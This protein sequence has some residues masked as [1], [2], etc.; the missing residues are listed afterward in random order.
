MYRGLFNDYRRFMQTLTILVL[1]SSF[2]LVNLAHGVQKTSPNVTNF[3]VS[4]A[5]LLTTTKKN[6]K[7][8]IDSAYNKI[9]LAY[10]PLF[11]NTNDYYLMRGPDFQA[12]IQADEFRV[13]LKQP[14]R[15]LNT[16]TSHALRFQFLGADSKARMNGMDKLPGKSNYFIGDNPKQWR[17]GVP[18]YE[19][20]KVEKIYPGIDLVYY[21]V[22]REME[23]DFVISPGVNSS[24]I[25]MAING[26]EDIVFQNNGDLV[27]H[28]SE[29]KFTLRQPVIYQDIAGQREI[30]EGRYVLL[31]KTKHNASSDYIIGFQLADYDVAHKIVIDPILSYATRIAGSANE[32]S[33]AIAVDTTGNI[34][35]TGWTRSVDFPGVGA[36]SPGLLGSGGDADVFV[37]KLAADGNTV[38]YSTFL[39]GSSFDSGV[40]IFVDD[41]NK[42]YVTGETSHLPSGFPTTTGAYNGSSGD[43]FISKLD[44]TGSGLLYSTFFGGANIST[45]NDIAV[46]SCGDENCI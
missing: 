36:G 30:V 38:L 3:H 16:D 35:L 26:V 21:S 46:H 34:Y 1:F 45:V 11:S 41:E 9:K 19:K 2:V 20:I 37:I 40:G 6:S 29:G 14:S 39:G 31:D 5:G 33:E 8:S 13:N 28:S 15:K 18:N 43:F 25:Q 7:S 17:I 27:L 32:I 42:A 10:E 4:K 12:L 24:I 44:A 22:N 23:F